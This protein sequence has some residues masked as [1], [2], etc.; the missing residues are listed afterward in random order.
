MYPTE[1]FNEGMA[2]MEYDVL[3]KALG[4]WDTERVSPRGTVKS[5][6]AARS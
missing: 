6:T 5:R 3:N 2:F 4:D 1:P